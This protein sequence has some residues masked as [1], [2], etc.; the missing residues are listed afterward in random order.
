MPENVPEENEIPLLSLQIKKFVI[1]IEKLGKY[2]S[3]PVGSYSS[4]QYEFSK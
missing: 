1:A 2:P 3:F 4:L